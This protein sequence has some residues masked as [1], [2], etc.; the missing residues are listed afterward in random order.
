MSFLSLVISNP[1]RV[2]RPTQITVLAKKGLVGISIKAYLL[3]VI[4]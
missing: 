1:L 2:T 3:V 4:L